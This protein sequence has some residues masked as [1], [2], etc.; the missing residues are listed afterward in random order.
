MLARLKGKQLAAS[1]EEEMW[2][3]EED[4]VSGED[5]E[6]WA[7]ECGLGKYGWNHWQGVACKCGYVHEPNHKCGCKVCRQ[8]MLGHCTCCLCD[9]C[10]RFGDG[11]LYG[12]C[13]CDVKDQCRGS[14]T[15]RNDEEDPDDAIWYAGYAY[16]R[17]ADYAEEGD[18]A[19]DADDGA[20]DADDADDGA[21]DAD[22]GADDADDA[23][24]GADD[25]D[26]ADDGADDADDGADDAEETELAERI[27]AQKAFWKAVQ[28]AELADGGADDDT[29]DDTDD[30]E[31]GDDGLDGADGDG[32]G[33]DGAYDTEEE[34]V[35]GFIDYGAYDTEEEGVDDEAQ[36]SLTPW[37]E[38]SN[39]E[40][41]SW[42]LLCPNRNGLDHYHDVAC[43]CQYVHG[44]TSKCGCDICR[45][46]MLHHCTACS[47]CLCGSF[48]EGWMDNHCRCVIKEECRGLNHNHREE[49]RDMG[50]LFD[51]DVAFNGQTMTV[52]NVLRVLIPPWAEFW[53]DDGAGE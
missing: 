27:A 31:E 5:L 45:T 1:T 46:V 13:T 7:K 36:Y 50:H 44:P 37:G 15:E 42:N 16:N 4:R 10:C 26:D 14:F 3:D 23:D 53:D 33:D 52:L 12:D 2:R 9:N 28:E 19:D 30:A 11:W 17:I 47:C 22:D 24:D 48:G 34:G 49:I 8:R 35:D 40:R 21:D 39:D 6:E 29:D 43:E 51:I 32:D 38:L 41:E 18:D 25:A 20:D